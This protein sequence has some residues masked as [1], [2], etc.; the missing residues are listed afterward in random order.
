MNMCAVFNSLVGSL[1]TL[2]A[3][4]TD[5]AYFLETTANTVSFT[6]RLS[7]AAAGSLALAFRYCWA[8]GSPRVRLRPIADKLAH[9]PPKFLGRIAGM[10]VTAKAR[11]SARAILARSYFKTLATTWDASQGSPVTANA[12]ASAKVIHATFALKDISLGRIT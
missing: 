3:F 4:P 9:E 2:R 12:R 6:L 11:A 5:T 1:I 8:A 10:P 7:S